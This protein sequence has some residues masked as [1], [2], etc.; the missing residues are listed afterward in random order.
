MRAFGVKPTEE[1]TAISKELKKTRRFCAV[2]SVFCVFSLLFSIFVSY[3]F[4]EATLSSQES[5]H[6]EFIPAK[7]EWQVPVSSS[8]PIPSDDNYDKW[9]DAD[10]ATYAAVTT[11]LD[12]IDNSVSILQNQIG[13][14]YS[15][16]QD[17]DGYA[18]PLL[19]EEPSVEPLAGDV[20]YSDGLI[21]TDGGVSKGYFDDVVANYLLIP[22]SVRHCIEND[23][24]EIWIVSSELKAENMDGTIAAMTVYD[25]KRIYITTLDATAII[26]EMGHYLDYKNG[27]CSQD[28]PSDVYA[29]ELNGFIQIDGNTHVRQFLFL[30]QAVDQVE[31]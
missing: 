6:N 23:D 24:W 27:F 9:T 12:R 7:E 14:L 11:R 1:Y 17:S 29:R 20:V 31:T 15:K 18:P 5:L 4:F 19:V 22:E 30:R 25:S 28:I 2:L 21:S 3:N 16:V 8:N 10:S 26:H 13:D